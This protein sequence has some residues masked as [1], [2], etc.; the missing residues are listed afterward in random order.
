M[1]DKKIREEQVKKQ[2]DRMLEE[3]DRYDRGG[4]YHSKYKHRERIVENEDKPV[5]LFHP[6]YYK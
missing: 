6:D 3:I 5:K 4:S 2:V 1:D